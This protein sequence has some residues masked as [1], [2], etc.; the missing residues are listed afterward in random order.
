MTTQTEQFL[1]QLPGDVITGLRRADALWDQYK[2]G[3]RTI[4]SVVQESSEPLT[5]EIQWDVVICGGTLG[6]LLGAALTQ[7]GWR[8]AL[9]ER[10]PLRGRAQE[11]NISRRELAVFTELGLLSAAEVEGAIASEYN[12]AR[13]SFHKGIDLWVEDVLNVGIDPINLL[14]KLKAK[15]LATGGHLLEYTAFVSATI[16]PNGA[17]VTVK[18]QEGER[19]L[20]TRLIVDA[21]GHFSAIANQA[22]QGQQPDAVCMV[23]G[24]CAQGFPQNDTGD[25]FASFTPIQDQRQ[26]FWEAFPA[27]DG[28]TTYLFTYLDADPQRP[29][30]EDLFE[31]YWRLLPDYQNV[32]LTD[33][34]L[35][36]ALFGFFP[37]YRHSPLQLPWDRMVAVGDSSGNQS[38]LS[39]GGFG[40]MLRHLPRLTQ[41][42]SAAVQGDYLTHPALALL[43]PYQPSLSV[44]W[45]FQTSMSV[46]VD[47]TLAANQ[48][49][50]L[51]AAVFCE[52]EQLGTPVLKPFLQ[53]VVQL[54]GLVQTLGRTTI[55]HPLT[56]LKVIPQ[57]GVGA[58]L[59]W[60]VHFV[61]LV[62]YTILGWLTPLW[63]VLM[64]FLPPPLQ[65]T[66][67]CW[68]DAWIYGAGL[69]H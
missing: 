21:M 69:D 38:P 47:Q 60:L 56:T 41:G 26:Y 67:Q 11:W 39:F 29:S 14:D 44:T 34:T 54:S 5:L 27:R 7:K 3:T 42:I 68:I 50:E 48:I 18:Q 19:S 53:D 28:R 10:G 23:V 62:L 55:Y 1:S 64:P 37:C 8:V 58:L 49:N 35:V 12:P 15:F 22:R 17:T 24:T 61:S 9:V 30:L 36:R 16:H 6:V 13:L 45:L 65:H 40:A 52:M 31:D 63:R 20:S 57:V 46:G 25:L 4:P 2:Q 59:E 32:K 51:L 66:L 33:L 43:Q